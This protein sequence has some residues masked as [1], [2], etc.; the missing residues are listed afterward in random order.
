MEEMGNARAKAHF[1]ANVPAGYPV[2]REHATVRER[3]K[4]IR[5]KYEH[6]RFVSTTPRKAVEES[7]GSHSRKTSATEGSGDSAKPV[8][9][10]NKDR[11]SK[12]K[13]SKNSSGSTTRA[14]A[15]LQK[16]GA[17]NGTKTAKKTVAAPA[18]AIA[19]PV[20][21]LDFSAEPDPP[22]ASPPASRASSAP[23]VAD[24]MADFQD[25][26]SAPSAFEQ[27]VSVPK[28]AGTAAPVPVT[29][30]SWHG[31]GGSGV[32]P[33]AVPAQAQQ[34]Q[35]PVVGTQAQTSQQ[36]EAPTVTAP[37]SGKASAADILSMYNSGA[38]GGRKPS[39][40]SPPVSGVMKTPE[41][42]Q[43]SQMM[44]SLNV[45]GVTPAFYGAGMIQQGNAGMQGTGGWTP[46]QAA[47]W[48]PR[49]VVG[50]QSSLSMAQQ[51]WQHQMQQ[52]RS[53]AGGWNVNP[54]PGS[55]VRSMMGQ[56]VLGV[57]GSGQQQAVNYRD[58]TGMAP[59]GAG[60]TMAGG[61]AGTGGTFPGNSA[62]G[63]AMPGGLG[64][65]GAASGTG[66]GGGM[67]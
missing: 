3:E 27:D 30:A 46:Q 17:T 50:Q 5:D 39:G 29:A 12:E 65:G 21:L 14:V 55:Q 56:N 53:V 60:V 15:P 58:R 8:R 1:E 18:S 34:Q 32:A 48:T 54:P 40:G 20:D 22:Q 25:F 45:G 26:Q 9:K 47:G 66:M 61:A 36:Q 42:N 52:Q 10:S 57:T 6:R 43:V 4:W 33:P 38:A 19:P 31:T 7:N 11:T 13:T 49:G 35:I 64:S 59:H 16:A 62:A 63:M 67:R 24:H 41:L 44:S 28:E 37:G 2:P 23:P 51:P